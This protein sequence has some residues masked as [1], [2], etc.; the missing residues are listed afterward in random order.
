M[1]TISQVTP[2]KDP[3]HASSTWLRGA[4]RPADERVQF[5][6]LRIRVTITEK[7]LV[8]GFLL[9]L[10]AEISLRIKGFE[11]ESVSYFHG[12]G[13]ALTQLATELKAFGTVVCIG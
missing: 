8:V 2:I 4:S 7:R 3:R 12:I 9:L 1:G 5:S 6:Q 13:I 11:S 10:S